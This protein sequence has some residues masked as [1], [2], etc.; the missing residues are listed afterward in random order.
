MK[1]LTLA[2]LCLVLSG[3]WGM[4]MEVRSEPAANRPKEEKPAADVVRVRGVA[5]FS[6][7]E[8][9]DKQGK[10]V[11]I[12]LLVVG[13]ARWTCVWTGP[14][15]D[16]NLFDPS[17]IYSRPVLWAG[18]MNS[19][20]LI[21]VY[22]LVDLPAINK[23]TP[24]LFVEADTLFKLDP[25]GEKAVFS[26]VTRGG[27]SLKASAL[28]EDVTR[29]LKKSDKHMAP[30]RVEAVADIQED[31]TVKMAIYRLTLLDAAEP[32]PARPIRE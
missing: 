25:K 3:V 23:V 9:K 1:G 13:K 10:K 6:Q 28:P 24:H 15:A 20:G 11:P 16:R 8:V 17:K 5:V 26:F 31:G 29:A 19:S 30:V 32:P 2:C 4:W 14:L 21:G 7:E 12:T 22:D 18:V 27:A